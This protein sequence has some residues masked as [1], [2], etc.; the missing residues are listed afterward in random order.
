MHTKIPTE[1]MP[2]TVLL[3]NDRWINVFVVRRDPGRLH[4][5]PGTFQQMSAKCLGI[6]ARPGKLSGEQTLFMHSSRLARHLASSTPHANLRQHPRRGFLTIMPAVTLAVLLPATC[7]AESTPPA[8]PA[9][10][11]APA[12]SAPAAGK[13]LVFGG[14]KLRLG[15]T[16]AEVMAEIERNPN[17]GWFVP[18]LDAPPH[19][20]LY[21]MDRWVL[22]CKAP[23]GGTSG[24]GTVSLSFENEKLAKIEG[25]R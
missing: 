12:A 5:Q 24:G 19:G 9:K 3:T 4:A 1:G 18:E 22:S 15:M 7:L 8:T 17:A 6:A 20:E 16:K 23:A 14:A 10:P 11:A 25:G 2:M 13:D 21:K